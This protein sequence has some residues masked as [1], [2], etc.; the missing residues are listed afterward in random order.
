MT[1]S[2]PPHDLLTLAD[3]FEPRT[4]EDWRRLVADVLNK[5][6]ADDDPLTPEAAEQALVT[7]LD[8]ICALPVEK[9]L[10]QRYDKFRSYGRFEYKVLAGEGE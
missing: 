4:R 3:G 9:L 2:S 7:A 8:E 10:K 6:R 5:R 1:T